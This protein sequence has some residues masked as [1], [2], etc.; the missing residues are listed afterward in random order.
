MK[1]L[2]HLVLFTCLFFFGTSF[3]NAYS[4]HTDGGEELMIDASKTGEIVCT[5]DIPKRY[6]TK[7]GDWALPVR[8]EVNQ[9]NKQPL[10]IVEDSKS[11]I[12]L[13]ELIGDYT[14]TIRMGDYV[15]RYRVH[16]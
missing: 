9:N 15:V 14:I 7:D 10:Y 8:I 11:Q 2:L 13:P 3:S 1:S 16:D 12:S 6:I 5:F 4:L